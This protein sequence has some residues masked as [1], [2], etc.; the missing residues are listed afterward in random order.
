MY[1]QYI[2]RR[3]VDHLHEQVNKNELTK[4]SVRWNSLFVKHNTRK[5]LQVYANRYTFTLES[6]RALCSRQY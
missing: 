5:N 2:S 1:S 6:F 3:R 4:A